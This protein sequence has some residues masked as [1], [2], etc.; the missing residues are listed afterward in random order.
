M[1]AS[2]LRTP[3]PIESNPLQFA[4]VARP[5]PAEGEALIRVRMCGV[6]RTDLHVIEG[7][8]PPRKS[9]IIP[10]PPSR[11]HRRKTW[12]KT[13]REIRRLCAI[14]SVRRRPR[15]HR[16]AASHR[17]NLPILPQAGAENLCDHPAFTGYTVDGGY[18]QYIVAPLD[19]VYAIPVQPISPTSKPRHSSAPELSDFAPCVFPE[20]SPAASSAFTDSVSPR[21]S[22][23]R[24]RATGIG[25]RL[26]RNARRAPPK[27]R[28]RTRRQVGWRNSSRRLR[29]NLD[30]A[31]VFAPAGEIVPAALA[32]LCAKAAR[33]C[34]AEFT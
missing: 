7:E 12:R 26:R 3:A 13:R 8:L 15:R 19:F 23:S 2:L 9:P 17:R 14:L 29:K 11:R 33:S 6:C 16:L 1:K 20:F 5:V 21:T 24:S 25:R 27:T 28:P 4:D 34:W 30:A 32:A 18:A 31:H 22:P 10:G